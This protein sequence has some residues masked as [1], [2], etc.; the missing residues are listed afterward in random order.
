MVY[1]EYINLSY[2]ILL[3]CKYE[4]SKKGKLMENEKSYYE[5]R[6]VDSMG[7][8]NV[9]TIQA[10]SLRSAKR[11]ATL[12]RIYSNTTLS[13]Y[14][15]YKTGNDCVAMRDPIMH[16]LGATGAEWRHPYYDY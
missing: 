5:I 4:Q 1:Y 6:E 11:Q 7:F 16:P 3:K 15:V 14:R 8:A 9:W 12:K 10:K 13:I 2:R